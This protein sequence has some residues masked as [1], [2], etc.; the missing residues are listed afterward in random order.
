MSHPYNWMENCFRFL[1]IKGAKV[2]FVGN[3]SPILFVNCVLANQVRY[4]FVCT[5]QWV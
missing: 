2:L 1:G 3:G 5:V 4:Q